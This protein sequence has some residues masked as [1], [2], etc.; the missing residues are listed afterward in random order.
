MDQYW[1]SVFNPALTIS[2]FSFKILT[3]QFDLTGLA[4]PRNKMQITYHSLTSHHW[5]RSSVWDRWSRPHGCKNPTW[6]VNQLSLKGSKDR[7]LISHFK[8]IFPAPSWYLPL[9]PPC[10]GS[11]QFNSKYMSPSLCLFIIATCLTLPDV[12][13][14]PHTY[15]A[16]PSPVP[17]YPVLS[18]VTCSIKWSGLFLRRCHITLLKCIFRI[19]KRPP[20]SNNIKACHILGLFYLTASLWRTGIYIAHKWYFDSC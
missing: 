7:R 15:F 3:G 9:F 16:V 19:W 20:C 13:L 4:S 17:S 11:V 5:L 12:S 14:F 8:P 6:T 18:Q 10:T 2:D 1:L